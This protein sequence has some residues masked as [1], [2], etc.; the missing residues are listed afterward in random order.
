MAIILMVRHGQNDMVGKKLAGRLP[1]IHLNETGRTQARQLAAA[2][3]GL[4]IRAIFSSP[5][6]RT[7]ETAQPIAEEHDLPVEILPDLLEIDF[8][9]WQGQDLEELRKGSDWDQVQEHPADFRFPKGESFTEAQQRM[10]ACLTHIS[11]RCQKDDLV[12]CV[13]HSDMIR[14]AVAHFLGVPLNEFQ[15][16]RIETASVTV[17]YLS[18]GKANF[19]AINHV[20][21]FPETLKPVD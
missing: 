10:A 21:A 15:R 5:L 16:L 13:G 14:L 7:L 17:L 2:F 6:E 1:D 8:G 9:G 12:V 11:E 4:P 3:S 20:F 18:E 19:G